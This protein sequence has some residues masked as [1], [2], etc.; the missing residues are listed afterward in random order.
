MKRFLI[1][2]ILMVLLTMNSSVFAIVPYNNYTYST[3]KN[4][5]LEPD[6][7]IPTSIISG[8]TLGIN[9]FNAPEDVYVSNEGN[10]FIADTA[11]NRILILDSNFKLIRQ[12]NSFLNNGKQDGFKN[13]SGVFISKNNELYVADTDNGR[14][15]VLDSQ[16]NFKSEF[17]KPQ[18]NLITTQ[19][20]YKPVKIAVDVAGR[21]YIVS[22]NINEGMVQL[23]KQGE[24]ISFFGAIEVKPD[25][26]NLFWKSIA[27]K[28]QRKRIQLTIPTEYSNVDIDE[29][30]FVFGTV[31][32]TGG[33]Y[34][35]DGKNFVR[36]LNPSGYNILKQNAIKPPMGDEFYENINGVAQTSKFIDV[37][38]RENGIYSTL[39]ER[40][41]RIFTYDNEGNLLFVFGGY[42]N[43]NGAFGS[44]QA[45]SATK[46]DRYLV[47]DSKYNQIVVF[48]PT[49]YANLILDAT[50]Y[51][52]TRNYSLSQEKWQEVLKYTSKSDIAF[53]GMG[54]VLFSQHKYA[55]AMKYFKLGNST[56]FYSKSFEMVR[57][58]IIENYFTI[59]FII[60]FIFAIL[61][62]IIKK[63]RLQF[64][65]RRG[66][67]K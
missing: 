60:I 13:P 29:S 39:D 48:E 10:I 20:D 3:S 11:N 43:Q 25:I 37:C 16:D 5:E 12:I 42:G 14:I 53:V 33:G 27:T 52:F 61:F 67:K 30:G 59:S 22:Q 31:S 58:I 66:K 63:F 38:A 34:V 4:P 21:M 55:E 2:T 36:K 6:A 65:E 15:V 50:R 17:K 44:P 47:V 57:Q 40:K 24:F 54:K 7:Y 8:N 35:S 18:S 49:K 46:D 62:L 41:G 56:E 32:A 28:E 1:T 51:N 23:D 64:F 19:F 45:I 26:A 9:E